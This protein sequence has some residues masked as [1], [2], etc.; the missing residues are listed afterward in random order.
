MK[1]ITLF[2]LLFSNVV[3]CQQIKQLP[4]D[5]S[6]TIT[7]W[8]NA[9]INI[10]ARNNGQIASG[11]AIFMIYH[12]RLLLLTARHVVHDW[13]STDPNKISDMIVL[14][15]N[16]TERDIKDTYDSA[17]NS[18]TFVGDF[19]F[20]FFGRSSESR[21]A[22]S[23]IEK[24]LAVIDLSVGIPAQ[25]FANTL[26]KRGYRPIFVKD[27][28]TLCNIKEGDKIMA[29]GYPVES[30]VDTNKAGPLLKFTSRFISLPMVTEGTTNGISD[31]IFFDAN[32]FVYHGFSGGPIIK[33]N[34][35][36]GIVHGG[37]PQPT[38]KQSKQ[39]P[40]YLKLQLQLIKSTHIMQLLRQ[41]KM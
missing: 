29:V 10:E 9:V 20:L 40:L 5:S 22:F 3:L 37:Y 1:K 14:I 2:L 12:D 7:K 8:T 35:L 33:N 38:R 15:E 16:L 18:Y 11:S 19:H 28:D 41:L 32:L 6:T 34:Q 30:E 24:D 23:S 13:T 31:N 17:R 26:F 36:I 39:L 27:I 21:W 25:S 4:I